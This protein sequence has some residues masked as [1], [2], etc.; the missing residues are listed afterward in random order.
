MVVVSDYNQ[1]MHA[2]RCSRSLILVDSVSRLEWGGVGW[3]YMLE[4]QSPLNV[5]I[6]CVPLSMNL[7]GSRNLSVFVTVD[8]PFGVVNFY[9]FIYFL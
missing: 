6:D 7:K 5:V 4:M 8:K 3:N 2:Q 1:N 9:L